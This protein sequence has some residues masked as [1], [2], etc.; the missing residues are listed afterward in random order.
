[1]DCSFDECDNKATCSIGW[2]RAKGTIPVCKECLI[3][4]QD[5]CKARDKYAF[6]D[7]KSKIISILDEKEEDY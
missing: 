1:M 6:R 7:I 5:H 3:I 2:G 4:Y